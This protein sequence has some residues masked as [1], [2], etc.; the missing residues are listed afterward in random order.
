MQTH[1]LKVDRAE[2]VNEPQRHREH[3]GKTTEKKLK[4]RGSRMELNL[5]IVD[6]LKHQA[7]K[8]N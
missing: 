4:M 6:S 5:R 8:H 2:D 1:L 3:R 7:K